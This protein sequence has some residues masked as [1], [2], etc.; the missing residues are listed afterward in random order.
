MYCALGRHLDA[1]YK[2]YEKNISYFGFDI[3]R[4]N[5][6]LTK[7]YFPKLYRNSKIYYLDI[8]D[9]FRNNKSMY[10]ISFTHGRSIDLVKP[11]FDM[12]KSIFNFTEHFVILVNLS[13]KSRSSHL[14][15]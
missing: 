1:I 7:K 2:I 12:V 11:D 9:F 4:E 8:K 15:F 3:N 6:I 5:K 10:S 14:R 13:N